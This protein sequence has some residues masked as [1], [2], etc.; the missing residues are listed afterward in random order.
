MATI[1]DVAKEAG[2]SKT[3]VSRV[4]NH[5]PGVSPSSR[6]KIQEAM[7]KLKYQPNTL[8]RSLVLQKTST[9]GV[10]MDSLSDA[11]FFKVI[12]G[13]E[14]EAA[15][16]KY[17]VIFS[18]A[19]NREIK[20][21]EYIDFFSNGNT[22][23]VIIYGSQLDDEA[24]IRR[25]AEMNFPFVVVENEIEN[26]KVNNVIVD[27]IYGSKLAIDHLVKLGCKKIMHVTGDT[28]VKASL[29]RWQGYVEAMKEQK[30]DRYISVIECDRFG[31]RV[32]YKVM[33][34]WLKSHTR[35]EW[36]DAVYF[37]ADN[38]AFGG[39]MAL[40]DAG[41]R[42]PEDIRIVGFDDDKPWD[43]ERKL[44]K[45]TSIRQ[46]LYEMGRKSV[47]LLIDQIN[48]TEAKRRAVVMRPEL[49]IRETT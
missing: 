13:I 34:A 4:I 17:K 7:K 3:L 29:R 43:V 2:V 14:D 6:E 35:Q 47:E 21:E 25:R 22:D 9:I 36:P 28:T 42:I 39:M 16:Q 32:G 38:T 27:N 24:L 41:A 18:S 33:E 15:R 49:I 31:V 20:K 45:L 44:K 48:D 5:Q 40:E 19:G 46:P 23:G 30:L 1:Y 8:A 12:N 26:V 10:V 37:G 11:Y